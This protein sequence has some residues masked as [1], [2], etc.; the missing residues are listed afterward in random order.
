MKK[1]IILIAIV[2]TLI[3]CLAFAMTSCKQSMSLQE[4]YDNLMTSFDNSMKEQVFLYNEIKRSG[5][6]NKDIFTRSVNVYSP[7]ID[8]KKGGYEFEYDEQ[9]R[10]KDLAITA[11]ESDWRQDINANT[12][13]VS[14]TATKADTKKTKKEYKDILMRTVARRGLDEKKETK[15]ETYDEIDAYTFRDS[16]AFARFELVERIKVLS[17]INLEDIVF[18]NDG[19][20]FYASKIA[21]VTT[22]AFALSDE[23]Y[24]RYLA[25]YGVESPLKADKIFIET[26]YN[27]ISNICLYNFVQAGTILPE[28]EDEIYNIKITYYGPIIRPVRV[29]YEEMTRANDLLQIGNLTA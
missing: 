6:D 26:A 1:K 14:Y 13:Y 5:K 25:E 4:A 2:I 29:N 17:T 18:N 10:L 24:A 3:I 22:F 20:K 8:Q 12:F 16:E 11:Q 19:K 9:G 15:V 23:Y 28:V 27:R 7:L 21:K